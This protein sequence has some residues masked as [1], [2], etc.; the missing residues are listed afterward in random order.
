[1]NPHVIS[2]YLRGLMVAGIVGA[3]A[4]SI[5][6][7]GHAA[8][9]NDAV[10]LLATYGDL[11]LLTG[12]R[13]AILYGRIRFAAERV[14]PSFDPRDLASRRRHDACVRKALREAAGSVG[15]PAP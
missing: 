5:V 13:A 11:R 8:D 10:Q 15:A 4:R 7:V 14:C 12:Q 2:S 6:T 1:V 9:G 3:L